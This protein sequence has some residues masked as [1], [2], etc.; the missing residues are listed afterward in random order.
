[1]AKQQKTQQYCLK[2]HSSFLAKYNWDLKLPIEEA[3]QAPGVVV[4]LADSQIL[5]WINELNGT[6]NYDSI[7]KAIRKIIKELKNKKI[8]EEKIKELYRDLYKKIVK[9]SDTKSEEDYISEVTKKPIKEQ[10]Q[11]LYKKLYKVQYREDYVC[12]IMDKKSD[13]DRANKGFKINGIEYKRL[14]TTTNGVKTSTVVYTSARLRDEL[15]KR[16]E[17][18][19]NK[20]VKLVPAKLGAYE[21]LCSSASIPVSWPKG[22]I[23]VNDAITKFKSDLIDIDDS[24]ISKEPVV[25]DATMQD[26]ENNASDGCSMMLPSLSMRWNGELNGDFEH[27]ISGCNLRCAWTKG[28]TFTF[29]YIEWAEK[30]IGSYI[31]TDVWGQERD[32]RDSELI[33]TESQ[34]KLWNTYSSWEDYYNNCIENHYTIRIAKTA[35]HEVDDIRQLNYQFIQPYELNDS[36]ISELISPTVDEIKDIMRFDYKKSIVYLCG[37]KLDDNNVQNAD[38]AARALMI[39]KNMIDDPYIYSKIQKMIQ[40]RIRDAKI[41]VLDVYG[42]FQI[43]AGDLV[44]LCESMFGLEPHGVLKSGEI[45]S[46]YWRSKGV[47]RVTCYRAP[48]SNA[49]SIVAQNISYSEEADYWFRYIDTCVVVNSFDTMPAAL[50]GF[51]F[52]GDLL[53]TTSNEVLLRNYKP[54]PAL[55]CIQYNASKV[56]VNEDDVILANKRGF[57]SKIGS[58]TNRITAMTSLMANYEP[59][60]REYETLRYRVQC[61]QAQQQAEIDKAKGIISNPMPKTWYMMDANRV[62]LNEDSKEEIEKKKFYQSICA[63]K[64]PYFFIYNYQSLKN[65]YEE[66][67]FN[68]ESKSKSIFSMDFHSLCAKQDKSEAETQFIKWAN[69]KNPIDM[70]PSVMNKICWKIEDEFDEFASIPRDKFDFSMIKSGIYYSKDVFYAIKR[71][72]KWYKAKVNE[73]NKKYKSKYY[74]NFEENIGDKDQLLDLFKEKCAILCPNKRELCDILIDIC[75][76]DRADKDLVWNVCGEEIIENLLNKNNNNLYYPK[77][78]DENGEFWCCGHQFVMTKLKMKG[79][80]EQ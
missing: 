14:L 2:L 25:K 74:T 44:C 42:N 51:D 48:M 70:S 33:L 58:I 60:S 55:N 37:S 23:V 3:R 73:L 49:H 12:I 10:V 5:T 77:K 68:V 11:D 65:E 45:Y 31:V 39:N 30:N 79:D 59:G 66:Y 20:D 61:G 54:L 63:C 27:T 43:L 47:N 53:F 32:L 71:E 36:D 16:I 57:G 22:I 7:A 56:C 6:E 34:L 76:S 35:P 8:N 17:N 18:G 40:R 19:R 75:Y 28:M 67:I 62:N 4:S 52:D 1:M 15:K 9:K 21:A 46:Q 29:D 80:E 50:N 64:K 38:L 78:V 69:D 41:G 13:Y 72:Y 26:I 24:D